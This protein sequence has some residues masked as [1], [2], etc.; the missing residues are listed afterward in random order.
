MRNIAKISEKEPE[1]NVLKSSK[2]N[3]NKSFG[4]KKFSDM[5]FRKYRGLSE[6]LSINIPKNLKTKALHLSEMV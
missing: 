3:V 6:G 4:G 1:F 5:S 2:L